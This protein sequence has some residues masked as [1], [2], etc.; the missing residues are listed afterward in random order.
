M[1]CAVHASELLQKVV[2][3]GSTGIAGGL[4]EILSGFSVISLS[5]FCCFS[6]AC[7][8]KTGPQDPEDMSEKLIFEGLFIFMGHVKNPGVLTCPMNMR[9]GVWG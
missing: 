3:M 4:P 1:A 6:L 7:A 8:R 5:Q 9:M 2:A